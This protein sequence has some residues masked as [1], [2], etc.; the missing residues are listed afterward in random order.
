VI[1][2]HAS[3]P[4]CTLTPVT[5]RGQGRV[6]DVQRWANEHR[7]SLDQAGIDVKAVP[8]DPGHADRPKTAQALQ[9]GRSGLLT[10]VIIWTSSE[11]EVLC[12]D[13][14][15]AVSV[16]QRSIRSQE[17][18]EALMGELLARLYLTGEAER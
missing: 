17:D 1:L 6:V 16:D 14:P 11:C 10:E 3:I 12:G 9:L 15:V 18:L 5:S 13:N 8:T 7:G 2:G 4:E